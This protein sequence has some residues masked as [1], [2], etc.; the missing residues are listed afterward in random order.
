M[1]RLK[2]SKGSKSVNVQAFRTPSGLS[3]AKAVS[4]GAEGWDDK[5]IPACRQ[6]GGFAGVEELR[7]VYLSI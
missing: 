7:R 5:A 4:R 1:K 2:V 3:E 6:A